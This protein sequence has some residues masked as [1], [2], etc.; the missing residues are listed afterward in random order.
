M[1]AFGMRLLAT[2]VAVALAGACIG[3]FSEMQERHYPDKDA[4][5]AGD[6]SGWIPAILPND[7]MRIREVHRLDSS[8]TWGCF[9]TRRAEEVR[10]LLTGL[11]AYEAPGPIANPP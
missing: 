6:P 11:R 9:N 3:P 7:A 8:R 1:E 4:A 2:L 10:A 5:R